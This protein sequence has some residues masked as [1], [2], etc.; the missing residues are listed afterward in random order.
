MPKSSK[1]NSITQ[2]NQ[3]EIEYVAGAGCADIVLYAIIASTGLIAATATITYKC[4]MASFKK[5]HPV[6]RMIHREEPRLSYY[7]DKKGY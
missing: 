5:V 1:S 6:L 7:N 2:I 4:A 3:D